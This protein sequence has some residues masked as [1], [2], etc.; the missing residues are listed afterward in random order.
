VTALVPEDR[1][2]RQDEVGLVELHPLAVDPHEDVG[3]LL[4]V[5]RRRD[6]QGGERVFLEVEQSV[7]VVGDLLLLFVRQAHLRPEALQERL[8]DGV[9]RFAVGP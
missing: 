6:L 9:A 3:H 4:L 2:Q 7:E 1:Q 8:D 5:D